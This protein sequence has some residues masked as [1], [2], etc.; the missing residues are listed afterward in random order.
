MGRLNFLFRTN[1]LD[2]AIPGSFLGRNQSG[3]CSYTMCIL[4]FACPFVR[5]HYAIKDLFVGILCLLRHFKIL[6]CVFVVSSF[7]IQFGAFD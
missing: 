7:N 5:D 4:G 6:E 3:S 1:H 2:L